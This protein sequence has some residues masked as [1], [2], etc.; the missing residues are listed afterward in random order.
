MWKGNVQ[1]IT[2]LMGFESPGVHPLVYLDLSGS[3]REIPL[4]KLGRRRGLQVVFKKLPKRGELY[5]GG[6]GGAKPRLFQLLWGNGG[7]KE[8][9][10]AER[11]E[12][13]RVS[14]RVLY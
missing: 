11:V 12:F 4:G 7:K 5:T 1:C 8:V 14:V 9:L 6:G 13:L 2:S 3:T 10:G